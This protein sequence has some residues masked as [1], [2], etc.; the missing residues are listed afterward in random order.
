MEVASHKRQTAIQIL[1]YEL[2]AVELQYRICQMSPVRVTKVLETAKQLKGLA[3]VIGGIGVYA[4]W[5]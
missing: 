3:G 1:H 5:R 4:G 2:L